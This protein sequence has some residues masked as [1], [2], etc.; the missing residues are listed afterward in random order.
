MSVDSF[1]KHSVLDVGYKAPIESKFSHDEK[2]QDFLFMIR[3]DESGFHSNVLLCL[4]QGRSPL[5]EA[6]RSISNSGDD[7][8]NKKMPLHEMHLTFMPQASRI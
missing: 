1:A 6:E 4:E 7:G 5:Q 8:N 3:N 2:R